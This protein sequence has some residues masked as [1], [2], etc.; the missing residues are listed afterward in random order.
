MHIG[1]IRRA[2]KAEKE[3]ISIWESRARAEFDKKQK[4]S[5][6]ERVNSFLA[7][8]KKKAALGKRKFP[9]NSDPATGSED[10]LE[11][12]DQLEG[13]NKRAVR[14]LQ[15][16]SADR[17][18]KKDDDDSVRLFPMPST[19]NCP[20]PSE[21]EERA[22]QKKQDL[23][24]FVANSEQEDFYLSG[25]ELQEFVTILKDACENR[26]VHEV[27]MKMIEMSRKFKG[28]KKRSGKSKIFKAYPAIGL[29]NVAVIISTEPSYSPHHYRI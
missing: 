23:R 9:F 20:Y 18:K 2:K 6:M 10:D 26:S 13:S 21:A 4:P 22:R 8:E 29:L 5:V 24:Q 28:T 1:F 11:D 25:M 14:L 12:D 16:T 3:L 7:A 27:L 17:S 19:T 15:K